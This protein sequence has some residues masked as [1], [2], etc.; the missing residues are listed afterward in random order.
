MPLIACPECHHQVST[1]AAACP[2]C[3]HPVAEQARR[4]PRASPPA[5]SARAAEAVGKQ[6]V[7][8][9]VRPSWWNFAGQF[10]LFLLIGSLLIAFAPS[11]WWNFGWL[12]LVIWPGVLL[13]L[14]FY[15]R[16]SFVMRIYADRVSVEE[17]FFSKE[18]SEFF[19]KDIRAVDVRQGLWSRLVG[20]GDVT[21]STAATV[22][23]TEEAPGV[24]HPNHIKDLLIAQRQKSTS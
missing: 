13:L 10:L 2:G 22:D 16:R 8:L 20:I 17:G 5:D 23:A 6:S 24:P 21:I 3:G 9:E 12:G 14:A 15:R 19:I 4:D 18:G 7:L 11:A 1:E